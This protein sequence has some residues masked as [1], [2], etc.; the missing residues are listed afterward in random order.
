M[1]VCVVS[2]TVK[3]PVLPPCAADGHSRNPLYYYYLPLPLPTLYVIYMSLHMTCTTLHSLYLLEYLI[4]SFLSFFFCQAHLF[5]LLTDAPF[6]VPV[7][8][9][10]YLNGTPCTHCLL[11]EPTCHSLCLHSIHCTCVAFPVP[12]WHSLYMCGIPI[13]CTCVVFTVPV[14]HSLCLYGIPCTCVTF[15]VPVWHS[16]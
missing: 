12:V 10:L 1:C 7:W 13:H 4:T 5:P 16:L 9:S 2:V 6:L 15:P 11:L 14:W 3:C 8:H